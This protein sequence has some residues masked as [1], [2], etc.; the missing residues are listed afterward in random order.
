MW[1]AIM[2]IRKSSRD[3]Y[4][5]FAINGSMDLVT[6]PELRSEFHACLDR[7]D[8]HVI[9]D[10]GGVDNL[11]SAGSGALLSFN[12]DLKKR[13]GRL[14]LVGLSDPSRDVLQLMRLEDFFNIHETVEE[15][16]SAYR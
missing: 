5:I 11:S 1:S 2:D 14:C 9:V 8:L 3:G 4:L 6:M 15:A 10:M 13:G 7:G 12:Q 16:V